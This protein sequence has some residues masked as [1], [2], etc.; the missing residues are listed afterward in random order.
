MQ[1]KAK[2]MKRWWLVSL[3]AILL[4]QLS[5]ILVSKYFPQLI[6]FNQGIAFGLLPSNWWLII[7]LLILG[8]LIFLG[9]REYWSSL[10]IGGGLS[11]ILDRII[12]EGVVDFID[13]KIWPVFNL[14]DVFI[15]LGIGFFIF[16]I[17]FKQKSLTA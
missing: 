11:N 10:L 6:T 1:K 17:L 14:A 7:N 8:A 16:T 13:I 5:K 12:R 4:D 9:K 3:G 15:S 2:K